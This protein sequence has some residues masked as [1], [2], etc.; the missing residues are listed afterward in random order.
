MEINLKDICDL[1]D[2][3]D[4]EEEDPLTEFI[5]FL[6][7]ISTLDH[8]VHEGKKYLEC[9]NSWSSETD[10]VR[11]AHDI[12]T[13]CSS[14]MDECE[15]EPTVFPVSN[16]S[17]MYKVNIDLDEDI[18]DIMNDISVVSIKIIMTNVVTFLQNGGKTSDIK[19]VGFNSI[20]L[21][22]NCG[23]NED[24]RGSTHCNLLVDYEEKYQLIKLNLNQLLVGLYRIKSH[25]FDKNY[26][27][28]CSCHHEIEAHNKLLLKFE[29]DHGS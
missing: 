12:D 9:S 16:A 28:F 17:V 19:L 8:F 6:Y 20:T 24:H 11:E 27:M 26:E 15:L 10:T 7:N 23:I 5:Q 1:Q 2:E 25:K 13:D 14:Y 21:K 3:L 4:G 29:F 18:N 22:N